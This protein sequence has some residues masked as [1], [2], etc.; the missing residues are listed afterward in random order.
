M[1]MMRTSQRFESSIVCRFQ[2]HTIRVSVSQW[3]WL[4]DWLIKCQLSV[5]QTNR[6]RV[7]DWVSISCE[8]LFDCMNEV[9]THSHSHSHSLTLRHTFSHTVMQVPKWQC[10]NQVSESVNERAIGMCEWQVEQS[11]LILTRAYGSCSWVIEWFQFRVWVLMFLSLCEWE[12]RLILDE[13]LV[14][15]LKR[16][17]K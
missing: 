9:C 7:I 1:L 5:D 14:T 15:Q 10:S 2:E 8:R 13:C 6:Y 4:I 11:L 16:E 17:I 12:S 3:W